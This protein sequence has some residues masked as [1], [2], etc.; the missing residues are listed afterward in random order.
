MNDIL[1]EEEI[2][3]TK[4]EEVIF[5]SKYSKEEI[6][7]FF[8]ENN[9]L[10]HTMNINGIKTKNTR[11]SSQYQMWVSQVIPNDL[12]G[13]NVLDVGCADGFYSFLCEQRNANRILA[14]DYEAFDKHKDLPKSEQKNNPN[15]WTNAYIKLTTS[16]PDTIELTNRHR[17]KSTY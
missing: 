11:T 10:Y 8:E 4:V 9:A 1:D 15:K 13:K 5:Q 17:F 7:K 3:K 14:I 16:I 2:K 6:R 12:T